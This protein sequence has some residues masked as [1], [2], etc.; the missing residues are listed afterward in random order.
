MTSEPN[1]HHKRIGFQGEQGAY[2]EQAIFKHH[3]H[4]V[5]PV[6]F[7]DLSDV[8]D[9]VQEGEVEE[10]MVP[11]ENAQAGTINKTYD[12][13]LDHDL[14]ITGECY[15]E[16][17]HFLLIHRDAT[18]DDVERVYSHPQALMQCED[19]LRDL[20]V[21]QHPTHDTAGG[22]RRVKESGDVHEA[23]IASSIAAKEYDLDVAAEEIET[24]PTNLT[25]FLTIGRKAPERRG[26]CKTSIVF[27]TR[28]IPA[29]LYKCL[30]GFATNDVN[31][32]K[33]ESRPE[34]NVNWKYMFYLDFEGHVD[35][36]EVQRAL[37][38][39][40][41]F[42]VSCKVMGSYPKGTSTSNEDQTP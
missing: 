37:D 17:N 15:L 5:R 25:R 6:P 19:F 28:D 26:N 32:T 38:E 30:G 39:L 41:H 3:D 27:E 29:A 14:T 1:N 12:L 35:D 22:A 8:F 20:G 33:L 10:G 9:A 40:N 18:I 31:L 11:V 42:T 4:E 13:L 16:I 36:P 24:R 34:R 7:H 21:D 2:S 23:A